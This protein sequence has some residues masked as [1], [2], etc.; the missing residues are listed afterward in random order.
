MTFSAPDPAADSGRREL[1]RRA[2]FAAVDEAL[3]DPELDVHRI[4]DT[5]GVSPRYVQILL[6]ELGTTPTALI[7][8]R[9]LELAAARFEREGRG[10]SITDV[11]YEVGFNDLSSFCRA[12]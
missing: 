4:A 12:S 11:A 2:L 7:R 8:S 9:R 3:C 6:A 5:L 10:C 1:L